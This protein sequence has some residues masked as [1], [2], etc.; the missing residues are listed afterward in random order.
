MNP[1]DR[2]GRTRGL[3]EVLCVRKRLEHRPASDLWGGRGDERCRVEA[4]DE[5]EHLGVGTLAR[6]GFTRVGREPLDDATPL[7]QCR[8]RRS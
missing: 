7:C 8:V 1:V 3:D 6:L 4:L 2:A 5:P